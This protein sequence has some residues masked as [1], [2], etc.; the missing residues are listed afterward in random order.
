MLLNADSK[1]SDQTESLLGAQVNLLILSCC[2]S[3]FILFDIYLFGFMAI[4]RLF[5][6]Y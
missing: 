5:P 1:D 2:G 3:F 6:S 4:L